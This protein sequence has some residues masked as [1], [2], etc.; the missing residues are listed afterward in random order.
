MIIYKYD[1]IFKINN[2]DLALIFLNLF[3][4]KI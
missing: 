2:T 4:I 3:L 1:K